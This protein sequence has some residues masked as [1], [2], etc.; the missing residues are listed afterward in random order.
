VVGFFA[1]MEV[2]VDGVLEEMNDAITGHDEDGA[3]ARAE[4]EAFGGH[5]KERG[6]HE[7]ACAESDEVAEVSLNALGADENQATDDIG[8]SGNCAKE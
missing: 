2:R 6:S 1:E 8:E 5:L 3:E 7:E 4:L